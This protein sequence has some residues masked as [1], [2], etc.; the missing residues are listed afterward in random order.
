[1][2]FAHS[3]RDAYFRTRRPPGPLKARVGDEVCWT[4]YHLLQTGREATDPV[5]RQQG[6]VLALHDNERWALVAWH[7]EDE[8]RWAALANL[9]HAGQSSLRLSE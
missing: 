8:P 3:D 6:Q 2:S 9:A 4:R 5:W 7:D 1:M